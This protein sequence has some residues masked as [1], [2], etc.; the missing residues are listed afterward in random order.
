VRYVL[1]GFLADHFRATDN[2]WQSVAEI[3]AQTN[4]T[5]KTV[6]NSIANYRSAGRIQAQG[7]TRNRSYRLDPD[8]LLR[9]TSSARTEAGLPKR[10]MGP[11]VSA[12]CRR[13]EVHFPYEATTKSPDAL[14]EWCEVLR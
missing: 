4:R 11:I 14:R 13:W 1:N 7:P 8:W 3:A 12:F 2:R 6:R 10:E 5:E 9:T